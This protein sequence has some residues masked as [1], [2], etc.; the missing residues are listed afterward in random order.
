MQY[1]TLNTNHLGVKLTDKALQLLRALQAKRQ[2]IGDKKVS[3][4][5]LINECVEQSLAPLA[6][7][8]VSTNQ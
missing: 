5:R 8:P 2:A 6:E 4:N 3:A 7:Y 1:K